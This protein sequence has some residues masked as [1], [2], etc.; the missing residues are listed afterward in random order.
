MT[1][2]ITKP[3]PGNMINPLHPL[4][5]GLVGF[6][7][8]NEGSGSG[9]YDIS[10]K[11]NHGTLTN[12]TINSQSS[13]W[14]GSKFGGGIS[15]DGYNNYVDCGS[16]DN[17]DIVDSFTC[18]LWIKMNQT[19]VSRSF[20]TKGRTSKIVNYGLSTGS[21]NNVLRFRYGTD[22]FL[23]STAAHGYNVNEWHYVSATVDTHTNV[24]KFYSD[25][26]Q[27]GNDRSFTGS[28]VPND[29][30]LLFGDGGEGW[31]NGVFDNIGIYNRAL[32]ASEIKQLY[33][34][35]FIGILQPSL[36]LKSSISTVWTG[37]INGVTNPAK[38]YG[39]PVANIAKVNGVS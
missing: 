1:P 31:F 32:S 28:L 9:A 27:L 25:G 3:K 8:M 18:G 16:N 29:E 15:F 5:H 10:G 35:P 17:L 20:F 12:M 13:G 23:D 24:L 7:L 26:V 37:T 38:I 4:A 33:K 22:L 14:S 21:G 39:I 6:W 11:N 30:S 19:T 36:Y 34:Q 2:P